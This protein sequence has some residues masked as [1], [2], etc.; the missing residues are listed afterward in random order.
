MSE[1]KN[2]IDPSSSRK[3]IP[4]HPIT[5]LFKLFI[6]QLRKR[7]KVEIKIKKEV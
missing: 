5:K 7:E 6:F 2:Y 3:D 1:E 4:E